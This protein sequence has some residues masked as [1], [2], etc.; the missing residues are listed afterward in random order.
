MLFLFLVRFDEEET[1][2]GEV[3]ESQLVVDVVIV[4]VDGIRLEWVLVVWKLEG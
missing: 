1:L 2:F 4:V 3:M